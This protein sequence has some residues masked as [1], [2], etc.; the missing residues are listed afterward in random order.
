MPALRP[1]DILEHER[2]HHRISAA[3]LKAGKWLRAAYEQPGSQVIVWVRE[4]RGGIGEVGEQLLRH[5]LGDGKSYPEVAAM[6][7][8]LTGDVT[9]VAKSFRANLEA[10]AEMRRDPRTLPRRI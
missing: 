8:R 3:A 1:V 6:R 5:I 4:G 2:S 9:F 7:D 10:V